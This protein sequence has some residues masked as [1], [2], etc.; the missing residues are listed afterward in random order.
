MLALHPR[1]KPTPHPPSHPH[2]LKKL[3]GI[4]FQHSNSQIPRR[5]SLGY[6]YVILEVG[7]Q[8]AP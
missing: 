5:L 2:Q 4:S 6:I 3:C 8:Q 7:T 1:M